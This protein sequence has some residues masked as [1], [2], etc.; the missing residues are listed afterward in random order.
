VSLQSALAAQIETDKD[1]VQTEVRR[2]VRQLDDDALT[3]RQAAE[4]A[5]I[6]LGPDVLQW[7]PSISP[8]TPAEVKERLGRI[9]TELES[10]AANRVAE[11]SYVTLEGQMSLDEVLAELQRATGNQVLG[12]ETRGGQVAASFDK[13]LY[14]DA[15][16]QILDQAGLTVDPYGGRP[17]TLVLKATSGQPRRS[18]AV[19]QGAFRF[20]PVRVESRRDLRNPAVNGARLT[21]EF[22]WE[23][24]LSPISVRQVIAQVQVLDDEGRN[25]L[26]PNSSGTMNPSIETGMSAIELVLPLQLPS[27]RALRIA[28][29]QGELTVLVPGRVEA[30]EFDNLADARS[31]EQRQAGVTVILERFRK[32][33]NLFEARVRVRFDDAAAALESHRGWIYNNK[34]YLKNADGMTVENI[35]MHETSR[36]ANEIGIGYLFALDEDPSQYRFVYETPVLMLQIPVQ[37]ELSDVPLP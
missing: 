8:Q 31:V 21:M 24:R 1:E 14:W 35:E 36:A 25:L 10:R 29:I 19:Y 16:D 2:L 17:N 18:R 4:K 33:V 26:G 22:S 5:L 34:A 9:R 6:D 7:L 23:P 28:T 11:P 37:Y 12:Y 15:L 3:N 30:F 27:R 13:T 32:N 20:E